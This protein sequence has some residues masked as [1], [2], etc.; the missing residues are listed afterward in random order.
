MRRVR[1]RGVVMSA[2]VDLAGQRFGRW[3]VVALHSGGR[4]GNVRWIA[5]CD[6]GTVRPVL[7]GSLRGGRS[8]SC[9]CA[10]RRHYDLN[11]EREGG[12]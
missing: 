3:R 11:R 8:T 6:C 5:Q 4:D 7:G 1:R 2:F 10:W 12:R 9:G